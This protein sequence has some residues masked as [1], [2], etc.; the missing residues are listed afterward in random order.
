M[1]NAWPTG[2]VIGFAGP[3]GGAKVVTPDITPLKLP[4]PVPQ[5]VPVPYFKVM[6]E[7]ALIANQKPAMRMRVFLRLPRESE[8]S[9]L[10]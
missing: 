10:P 5:L 6:S 1:Q 4:V 9:M 7:A 3:I 8:L 2:R